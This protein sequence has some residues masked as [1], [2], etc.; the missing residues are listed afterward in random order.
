MYKKETNLFSID[1]YYG[2]LNRK[3]YTLKGTLIKDPWKEPLKI[4]I[5]VT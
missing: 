2:N 1:P 4:P 5:M 3:S